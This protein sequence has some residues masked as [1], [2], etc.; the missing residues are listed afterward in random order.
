MRKPLCAFLSFPYLGRRRADVMKSKMI[1]RRQLL[2]GAAAL[3]LGSGVSGCGANAAD[4]LKVTLLEG[5]VPAEVLQ[6]FR[7]QAV[8]P[9]EFQSVAQLQSVFQQLQRWQKPSAPSGSVIDRWLPN[10]Q[11]TSKA[12]PHNLVSLGD[13][14][15]TSAI[16]QNLLEPLEIPAATLAKLPLPWQQFVSR[17]PTG[18]LAQPGE[19]QRADTAN[20]QKIWAAPYKVQALVIVYRQSQFPEA[21]I[22][23]PP[24]KRWKDLLQ[25]ALRQKIILP[26]HPRIVLGLAQ[27]IQRDRFNFTFEINA[28]SSNVSLPA[29]ALSAALTESLSA[30]FAQLNQQVKAYDASNS[31]KALVN[32]D[33]KAAVGWSGEVMAALDRYQD[34]KVVMPAGGSLLSAD[35]WVRPKGAP[36]SKAA[37]QWIDFCWQTGPATQISIANK[38][39]SPLFLSDD[40]NLNARLPAALTDGLLSELDWA[41]SEL[42]LPLPSD[43]QAAYFAVWQ[44]LRAGL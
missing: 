7:K 4:A 41:H 31:L 22:E 34:L 27:K 8:K 10:R 26:D 15:L 20:G 36:M 43:L 44:Q 19:A 13:Y 37:Q 5:A 9:V 33:A 30:P 29:K 2:L 23:N 12:M 14:W 17:T 3:T 35:M 42:L 38:G 24:F 28:D 21:S 11:V 32:E 1:N 16:A 40:V 6:Q 18:Q 39:L 25:P